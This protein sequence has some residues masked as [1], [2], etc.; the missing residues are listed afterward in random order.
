M[1]A[2]PFEDFYALF[3]VDAGVCNEEL[4]KAWR[5]LAA[6]CHPDRA[7]EGATAQFQRLSAAYTVLSDP[8]ARAAYD[9]RRRAA[10]PVGA[11][12]PRPAAG[13]T[14]TTTSQPRRPAPPAVMLSR[15]CGGLSAVI[16]RGAAHLDEPGFVT[17]M[18]RESEAAQ[19]GMVSIAMRVE[20]R[21]AD[22]AAPGRTA[23]CAKCGGRRS[24]EELYSAWLAL[25]PGIEAGEVLT[26]SVELP[27]MIEPVR[28]RVRI[29]GA[30]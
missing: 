23:A 6:R 9:R 8:L 30:D 17:L 12:A 5:R 3:E 18:L 24:V 26:P 13:A 15:L 16:G 11:S 14:A 1:A 21:C 27:G 7:G 22:C 29:R 4:R 25:P 2:A 20:V 10:M 19:G 28:F